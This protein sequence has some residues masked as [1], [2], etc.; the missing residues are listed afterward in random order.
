M[1]IAESK[2]NELYE[3]LVICA[4][5]AQMNGPAFYMLCQEVV[6]SGKNVGDLTLTEIDRMYVGAIA[7]YGAMCDRL[8]SLEVKP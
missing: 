8:E 2:I 6:K 5:A 4:D 3:A 1:T 7:R